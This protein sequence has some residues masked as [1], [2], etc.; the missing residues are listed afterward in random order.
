MKTST[1]GEWQAPP[2]SFRDR[3]RDELAR[4]C[5]ANARYSVRAFAR[6]LRVDAATLS[7]L[8]RGKRRMTDTVI[9]RLG[10][11]LGIEPAKLDELVAL[12]RSCTEGPHAGDI[13]VGAVRELT[14]DTLDA[15]GSWHDWAILELT[16]T[17]SFVPD[18]RWI[19]R[20]LDCSVDDVQFASIAWCA[21]AS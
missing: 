9:R 16:R 3:L 5:K 20:V 2:T 12:E 21:S 19:A 11:R 6:F 8:L 1:L 17:E 13:D 4:R 18:L 15:L 7:Q 10:A 14:A